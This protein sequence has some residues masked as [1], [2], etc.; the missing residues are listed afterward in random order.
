MA[1][2]FL[3]YSCQVYFGYK[4]NYF[5]NLPSIEQTAE[6]GFYLLGRWW[7]P[8]INTPYR[9]ISKFT[10]VTLIYNF[11]TIIYNFF[12]LIDKHFNNIAITV[13]NFIRSTNPV[14]PLFEHENCLDRV[15]QRGTS[16]LDHD[17]FD[18]PSTIC[19]LDCIKHVIFDDN[20][21]VCYCNH[22]INCFLLQQVC[23]VMIILILII[24]LKI[25]FYLGY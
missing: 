5:L 6:R 16:N 12:F 18:E 19:I 14:H 20:Q 15:I 11:K 1:H 10:T 8:T 23:I 3:I 9:D 7:C 22:D 17:L 21:L 13:C 24:I 2:Q 25:I 4:I